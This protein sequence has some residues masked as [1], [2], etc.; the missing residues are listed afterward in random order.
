VQQQLS[1]CISKLSTCRSDA[2]RRPL[3]RSLRC[4]AVGTSAEKQALELQNVLKLSALL[5]VSR[6]VL[7]PA[8]PA[9]QRLSRVVRDAELHFHSA[10][11]PRLCDGIGRRIERVRCGDERRQ[12]EAGGEQLERRLKRAAARADDA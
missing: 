2:H 1:G 9:V 5:A 11:R 4:K 6:L 3:K 7:L 10:L 8:C 12:I